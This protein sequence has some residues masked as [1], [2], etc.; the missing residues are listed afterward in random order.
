[1]K[2]WRQLASTTRRLYLEWASPPFPHKSFPIGQPRTST[3]YPCP[4]FGRRVSTHSVLLNSQTTYSTDF[5]FTDFSII[6]FKWPTELLHRRIPP[7]RPDRIGPTKSRPVTSVVGVSHAVIGSGSRNRV[8]FAVSTKRSASALQPTIMQAGRDLAA[9]R[10]IDRDLELGG[11]TAP[12]VAL[13]ISP[14]LRQQH[15]HRRQLR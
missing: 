14:T 6:L 4:L 15:G 11:Q 7:L 1:M 8:H 13:L 10:R 3:A 2:R 5:L 9:Q 12:E